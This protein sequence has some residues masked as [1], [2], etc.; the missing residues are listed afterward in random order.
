MS[1]RGPDGPEPTYGGAPA[2]PP[3]A[4]GDRQR[5]GNPT[6]LVPRRP[7]LVEPTLD[8]ADAEPVASLTG[9]DLD[10]PPPG[11]MRRPNPLFAPRSF[12]NGRIQAWG[13]AP[14]C[15]IASLVASVLLTILLN[16][17]F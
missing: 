1:A 7:P 10:V 11:G 14:G 8:T 2:R 12:G 13:L 15:L 17:V 6:R 3:E 5:L 16:I 9:F 4:T